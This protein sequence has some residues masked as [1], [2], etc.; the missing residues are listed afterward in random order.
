MSNQNMIFHASKCSQQERE[1]VRKREK[2][3][4]NFLKAS[5]FFTRCFLTCRYIALPRR[6]AAA[7]P[8][9]RRS[10]FW[11]AE[12]FLLSF[13]N[14]FL[15]CYYHTTVVVCLLLKTAE[16]W[17]H[18]KVWGGRPRS[19]AGRGSTAGLSSLR[20]CWNTSMKKALISYRA[21]LLRCGQFT[22]VDG[23]GIFPGRLEIVC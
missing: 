15:D 17:G 11:E 8:H 23:S 22:H 13:S 1:R 18:S 21:V 4:K 5:I 20:G 7:P 2:R 3:E 10:S 19:G 6:R 16:N 12:T 14:C 9:H